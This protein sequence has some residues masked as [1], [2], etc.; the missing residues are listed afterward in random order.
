MFDLLVQLTDNMVAMRLVFRKAAS[1]WYTIRYFNTKHSQLKFT[2]EILGMEWP[3]VIV[4][5]KIFA[6]N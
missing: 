1:K 4:I 2:T 6:A 5:R 3:I